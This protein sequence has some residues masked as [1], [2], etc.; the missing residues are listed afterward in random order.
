MLVAAQFLFKVSANAEDPVPQGPV[1][2]ELLHSHPLWPGNV[3]KLTTRRQ[4]VN[5]MK[6]SV[7]WTAHIKQLGEEQATLMSAELSLRAELKK[8]QQLKQLERARSE[9]EREERMSRPLLTRARSDELSKKVRLRGG[10]RMPITAGWRKEY[11]ENEYGCEKTWLRTWIFGRTSKWLRLRG[12]YWDWR[13]GNPMKR[14]GM[15]GAELIII[16]RA[17]PEHI[18]GS[19]IN[20]RD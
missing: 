19:C 20:T 9:K 1:G 16:K 6:N 11:Y 5:E 3:L 4:K 18:T 7:S 2:G 17:V 10:T 14:G 15:G 12:H 8:K 13:V